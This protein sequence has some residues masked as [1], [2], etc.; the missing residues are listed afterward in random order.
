MDTRPNGNVIEQLALLDLRIER[1]RGL[2]ARGGATEA[3]TEGQRTL[4]LL[5]QSREVLLAT[6]S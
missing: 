6:L 1:V 3:L 2:L 4:Q 5:L